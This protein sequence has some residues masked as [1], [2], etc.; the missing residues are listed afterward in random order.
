VTPAPGGRGRPPLEGT[1]PPRHARVLAV[2]VSGTRWKV[3]QRGAPKR[4]WRLGRA[5]DGTFPGEADCRE[6]LE[7]DGKWIGA[8]A[9]RGGWRAWGARGASERGRPE[10]GGR[11]F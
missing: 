10:I 9:T 5:R 11:G 1:A 2:G 6:S 3:D 7:L 8:D 4:Q